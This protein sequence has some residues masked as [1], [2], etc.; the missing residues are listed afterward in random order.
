MYE[1]KMKNANLKVTRLRLKVIEYMARYFQH[2]VTVESFYLFLMKQNESMTIS[3]LYRILREFAF[4]GIV[5][6]LGNDKKHYYQL[7]LIED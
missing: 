3:T 2:G 5:T 6:T 4:A 1:Q 7:V